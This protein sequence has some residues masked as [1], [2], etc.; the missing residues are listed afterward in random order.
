MAGRGVVDAQDRVANPRVLMLDRSR[1]WVAAVDPIHFD[2]P[3]AGVG[4]AR[5]FGL[6]IAAA[7][8]LARV[9]LVPAAVGGSPI[10][11][12]EPGAFDSATSTHPYDDAIARAREAMKSGEL[13]AILWHQGESDSN[14]RDA[15]LYE[16]RLRALIERFRR[17]LGD[18][19]L[20]VLIGQLGRFDSVPWSPARARV[21]SAHRTLAR[22]MTDVAFVS[23]DGLQHKGD[24]IHF[25]SDAA[26]EL[27]RRYAEAWLRLARR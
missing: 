19:T 1:Q 8:P 6:V 17:E 11:S 21:D 14:P 23:A 27:G 7:N 15:P 22:G 16:Q 12:W 26:R 25:S 5:T 2:K 18:P 3:I 20:P 4:P 24:Q 10:R 13:R 9:G